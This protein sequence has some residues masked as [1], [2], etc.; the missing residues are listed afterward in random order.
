M[1]GRGDLPCIVADIGGTNARFATAALGENERVRL[2]GQR[3]LRVADHDGI[4]SA[5][6]AYFS[7]SG[8]PVPE[9][10][11]LAVAGA[12]L[13]DQVIL[14]NSRWS[15]SIQALKR[16]IGFA[17]LQVINDFAVVYSLNQKQVMTLKDILLNGEDE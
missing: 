13:D 14:T 11:V 9:R 12:V 4:E 15:F 5:L 2:A 3:S 10:A 1:S 8:E 16:R 6:D 7:A 17:E